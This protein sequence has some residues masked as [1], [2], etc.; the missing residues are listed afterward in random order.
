MFLL[1]HGE[2]E[3]NRVGRV[4]GH[5]DSPLTPRGVA[6]AEAIGRHL[7]TLIGT[8][9]GWVVE[10]SPLGRAIATATIIREQ[11]GITAGLCIDDRLREISLGSWDGLTRD[12]IEARWPGVLGPSLRES[13]TRS[14][15]DGETLAAAVARLSDWLR[16]GAGR[17]GR[18]IVSHGIAGCLIRGIYGRLPQDEMLRLP[19]PQESFHQLHEGT[20]RHIPCPG[21][22]A[23]GCG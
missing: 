13:W 19:T 9:A 16:V 15:P 10:S 11:T 2:T 23:R 17:P 12:E 18:I 4:Q 14:C 5:L 20:I 21:F 7:R 1:R 6:Q 22:A 3:F 8:E